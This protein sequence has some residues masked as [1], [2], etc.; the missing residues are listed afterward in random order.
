MAP[1]TPASGPPVSQGASV[2]PRSPQT[3]TVVGLPATRNASAAS[4][5]SSPKLPTLA[6]STIRNTHLP[7]SSSTQKLP[8]VG[9]STTRNTS[10]STPKPAI[11]GIST[12]PS[13]PPSVHVTN[14]VGPSTTR[15]IP[16]VSGQSPGGIHPN[17]STHLPPI[18]Q[19]QHGKTTGGGNSANTTTIIAGVLVPL[20]LIGVGAL[21]FYIW[22]RRKYPVRMLGRDFNR[23]SNPAYNKRAS[24]LTLVRN[25]G[26]NAWDTL[27]RR[28]PD[29]SVVDEKEADGID[30]QAFE[31]EQ[32]ENNGD[33]TAE[34]RAE[35]GIETSPTNGRELE[36]QEENMSN[37]GI[38]RERPKTKKAVLVKT[39][40]MEDL[41]N[42]F[43][44]VTE[45]DL[46][47]RTESEVS[48]GN[49][50]TET[51][52]ISLTFSETFDERN[53]ED[54]MHS[55]M[56]NENV[57]QLDIKDHETDDSNKVNDS[58]FSI[59]EGVV[60]NSESTNDD[61]ILYDKEF[62]EKDIGSQY[63]KSFEV[64]FDKHLDDIS[65]E[66]ERQTGSVNETE[67]KQMPTDLLSKETLA[68]EKY[69][70]CDSNVTE[71]TSQS[72]INEINEL[73]KSA[74]NDVEQPDNVDLFQGNETATTIN[75]QVES[76]DAYNADSQTNVIKTEGDI[77]QSASVSFEH[78]GSFEIVSDS[79]G[80]K[81]EN[82]NVTQDVNEDYGEMKQNEVN[83]LEKEKT[84]SLEKQ[85]TLEGNNN[86]QVLSSVGFE[87]THSEES[88]DETDSRKILAQRK[89]P[90]LNLSNEN[91]VLDSVPQTPTVLVQE[92]FILENESP[93]PV[94]LD[95]THMSPKR[96]RRAFTLNDIVFK[97]NSDDSVSSE[98]S[99]PKG[100]DEISKSS[101]VISELKTP[102]FKSFEKDHFDFENKNDKGKGVN[103]NSV[104]DF[105]VLTSSNT[106]IEASEIYPDKNVEEIHVPPVQEVHD[107]VKMKDTLESMSGFDSVDSHENSDSEKKT[108]IQKDVHIYNDEM[109]SSLD[110]DSFEFD[111]SKANNFN[112]DTSVENNS[113]IDIS[114]DPYNLISVELNSDETLEQET[115]KL[116][117]SDF[118]L[119]E[120]DTPDVI[121]ENSTSDKAF[122]NTPDQS[123]N[124]AYDNREIASEDILDKD[125]PFFSDFPPSSTPT[126]SVVADATTESNED[127]K[128]KLVLPVAF[129]FE[130]MGDSDTDSAKSDTSSET[131]VLQVIS[132]TSSLETF[133]QNASLSAIESEA[134][135]T[136][137]HIEKISNTTQPAEDS[138]TTDDI[139]S[140]TRSTDSSTALSWEILSRENSQDSRSN[141]HFDIPDKGEN[142]QELLDFPVIKN[143]D[144]ESDSLS[145]NAGMFEFISDM[146]KQSTSNNTSMGSSGQADI[147]WEVV[148]E[149]GDNSEC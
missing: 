128:R 99:L 95:S 101:P 92:S 140:L 102:K 20:I 30:N 61:Q 126:A 43:E 45:S 10:N 105:S 130:K 17:Y 25:D 110:S 138:F 132:A 121:S 112:L 14:V 127:C 89:M 68:E 137:D 143:K 36:G 5:S 56:D 84:E 22:Y 60:G 77:N 47:Q 59:A 21:I 62:D 48:S 67:T 23:F 57:K 97:Q 82:L 116:L 142:A 65:T 125:N 73:S 85:K 28:N 58:S 119:G 108:Y 79:G 80:I 49:D 107:T 24:T 8:T 53:K 106:E 111:R 40:T 109:L 66:P 78:D 64:I 69:D 4:S 9:L 144:N 147:S 114:I 26:Q 149:E 1:L 134:L 94:Y 46:G 37:T 135:Q 52:T 63:N 123:N 103:E 118:G 35:V 104:K 74:N 12:L 70:N 91:I 131:S 100:K 54:Q 124:K 120:I 71:T 39:N 87:S 13:N 32:Y 136:T 93:L 27:S 88:V 31:S 3:V 11:V 42:G 129:D 133:E 145:E 148:N 113:F 55:E 96:G 81:F 146:S 19:G 76:V 7:G 86:L 72:P 44:L 75:K 51:H 38:S 98:F 15:R 2:G 18:S 83:A 117:H 6:T 122:E 34:K 16:I 50:S 41:E 90:S 29:L 141:D 115:S 139:F 33:V